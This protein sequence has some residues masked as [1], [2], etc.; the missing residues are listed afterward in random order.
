MC[1]PAALAI[2]RCASHTSELLPLVAALFVSTAGAT[3]DH[4]VKLTVLSDESSSNMY[5]YGEIRDRFVY[6]E[7]PPPA[8]SMSPRNG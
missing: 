1:G 3:F 5:T 7:N 2:R 8:R 6:T 4:V